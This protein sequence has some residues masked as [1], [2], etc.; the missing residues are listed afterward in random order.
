MEKDTWNIM[1][2]V[3]APAVAPAFPDRKVRADAANDA[4][5]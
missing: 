1:K 2:Q 5:G 3:A 4:W